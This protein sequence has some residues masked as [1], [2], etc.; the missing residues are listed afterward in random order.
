MN[1]AF[2][3]TGNAVIRSLSRVH[4]QVW[5]ERAAR[6]L[7]LIVRATRRRRCGWMRGCRSG[8]TPGV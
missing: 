2:C 8:K 7:S 1:N 5:A 3:R 6:S 4:F